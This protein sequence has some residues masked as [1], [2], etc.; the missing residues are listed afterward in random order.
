ME[1]PKIYSIAIFRS[2]NVSENLVNKVFFEVFRYDLVYTTEKLVEL[3]NKGLTK[4]GA[5]SDDIAKILIKEIKAI[6]KDLKVELAEVK[7][8]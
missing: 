4:I 5:Y 1:Q 7:L 8:C 6:T 3:N 2:D